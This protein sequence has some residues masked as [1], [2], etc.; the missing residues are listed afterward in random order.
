MRFI[1][2]VRI[3]RRGSMGFQRWMRKDRR[4]RGVSKRRYEK[5]EKGKT[6]GTLEGK[7]MMGRMGN[8]EGWEA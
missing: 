1:R 8:W 2:R 7:R 5:E 4:M 3:E 6:A